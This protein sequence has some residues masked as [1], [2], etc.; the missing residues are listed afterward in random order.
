MIEIVPI[1]LFLLGWH[2]DH[3]GAPELQRV[4]VVYGSLEACEEAGA[5]MAA[6]MTQAAS[7]STGMR[8]SHHC[9]TL[10]PDQ[11]FRELF[12]GNGQ[13]VQ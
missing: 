8:Y 7:E 9:Q 1:M 10:P 5:K 3:A 6:D 4:P 12:D 2:P 13:Y 11:E